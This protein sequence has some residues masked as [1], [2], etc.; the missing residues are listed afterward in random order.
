MI[1]Q[2]I[3]FLFFIH[4]QAKRMNKITKQNSYVYPNETIRSV[5]TNLY[6]AK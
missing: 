4:N 6:N 1:E 3:Q 5:L 2:I